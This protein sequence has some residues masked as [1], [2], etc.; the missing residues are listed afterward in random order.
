MIGGP[1]AHIGAFPVEEA[2][3]AYGPA[4]LLAIGAA[5]A[6]VSARWR[7]LRKHVR[8]NA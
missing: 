2:V 8:R 7:G 1:S 5:L 4:L 6:R 3:A